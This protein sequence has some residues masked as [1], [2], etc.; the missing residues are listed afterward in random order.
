MLI[1]KL[2]EEKR[3]D[4]AIKVGTTYM[5]KIQSANTDFKNPIPFGILN[6]FTEALLIKNDANALEQAKIMI[7]K[8][9]DLKVYIR[10]PILSNVAYLAL[11]QVRI[12]YF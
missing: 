1:N 7:K 8:L 12:P 3:I 2:I 5:E 4:E 10:S 9:I 6:L 11:E